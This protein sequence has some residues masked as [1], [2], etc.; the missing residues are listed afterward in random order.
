MK[1]V[2]LPVLI[3]LL[4]LLGSSAS[5]AQ[6]PGEGGPRP[7]VTNAPI[8]GGASLLLAGGAAYALKRLRR[9]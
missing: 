9:R 4:V 1:H 2:F 3:L 7:G 6:G 5:Q 8:D